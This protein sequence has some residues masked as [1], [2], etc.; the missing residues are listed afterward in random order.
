MNK[1]LILLLMIWPGIFGGAMLG[2]WTTHALF[3]TGGHMDM[4]G[5]PGAFL[6]MFLGRGLSVFLAIAIGHWV[7]RRVGS[8][9]TSAKV[10]R[11]SVTAGAGAVIGFFAGLRSG[12]PQLPMFLGGWIGAMAGC[13][14]C[15]A[16]DWKC[17]RRPTGKAAD[18]PP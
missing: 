6:G 1:I 8:R 14:L 17:A 15:V 9:L 13:V 4:S 16:V 7:N 5:V 2:G 11:M 10:K 18:S 3:G 12:A